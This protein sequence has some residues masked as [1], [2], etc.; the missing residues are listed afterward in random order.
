MEILK[1]YDGKAR[2]Y[3]GLNY[4]AAQGYFGLEK[5]RLQKVTERL[6]SPPATLLSH[7][8]RHHSFIYVHSFI[9]SLILHPL[10]AQP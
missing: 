9:R 6:Y 5:C 2:N 3:A 7:S 4:N 1:Q 8:L 10:C